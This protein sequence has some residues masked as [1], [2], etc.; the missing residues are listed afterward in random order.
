MHNL[1]LSQQRA[2]SVAE[3]VLNNEGNFLSDDTVEA[4]KSLLTVNGCA[5]KSPIFRE[6]GTI[7]EEKSRRVEIKFRL[8]D[9]EMIQKMDEIL[10]N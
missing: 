10:N 8:K 2:W 1:E 6:D 7:D 9:Q 5:D 4:L 3:F